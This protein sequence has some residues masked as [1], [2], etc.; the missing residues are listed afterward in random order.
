MTT[1]PLWKTV[2][3]I[4]YYNLV[5]S[6]S[7]LLYDLDDFAH[8]KQSIEGSILL[9]D[10]PLEYGADRL[11]I[12]LAYGMSS[13]DPKW[14][15]TVKVISAANKYMLQIFLLEDSLETFAAKYP[16]LVETGELQNN[17]TL[18]YPCHIHQ[19]VFLSGSI[20]SSQRDVLKNLNI[21]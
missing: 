19:H 14:E 10:S 11:D 3:S 5:I 18:V 2:S 7:F 9:S 8:K 1:K 21:K 4:E 20:C 16:F 15:E 13:T 12:I 17:S 6:K